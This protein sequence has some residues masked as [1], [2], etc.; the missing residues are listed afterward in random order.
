MGPPTRSPPLGAGVNYP[1]L[2]ASLAAPVAPYLDRE[3]HVDLAEFEAQFRFRPT[4]RRR[5]EPASYRLY[6]V[7]Q[8][9]FGDVLLLAHWCRFP[10]SLPLKWSSPYDRGRLAATVSVGPAICVLVAAARVTWEV[11]GACPTG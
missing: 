6:R 11:I 10:V 3:L 2:D 5:D 9:D 4:R 7:R 1:G 8:F